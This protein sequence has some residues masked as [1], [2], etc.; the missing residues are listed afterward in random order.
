[1]SEERANEFT[2]DMLETNCELLA[3]GELSPARRRDLFD[4]LEQNPEH[5]RVCAMAFWDAQSFAA[6]IRQL[7]ESLP[8]PEAKLTYP[9]NGHRIDRPDRTSPSQCSAVQRFAP[10]AINGHQQTGSTTVG[11]RAQMLQAETYRSA[12]V[13]NK[14]TDWRTP[15]ARQKLTAWGSIAAVFFIGLM[16]ALYSGWSWGQTNRLLQLENQIQREQAVIQ[17]SAGWLAQLTA[18]RESFRSLASFFPDQAQLIEIE[19]TADRVV[20]LTDRPLSTEMVKW[21]VDVNGPVQVR[22]Y[23]PAIHSTLW[24]TYRSPVLEVEV[25]KLSSL[26]PN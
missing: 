12:A 4:F 16:L 2:A 19:N 1:M 22:P 18:E 26:S 9:S 14:S 25:S 21:L 17:W 5:W 24:E 7:P 13:A 6:A 23:K 11:K 3:A 20:F 8:T 15:I 10:A